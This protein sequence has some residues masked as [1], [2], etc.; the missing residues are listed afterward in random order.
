[1]RSSIS[2]GN[3]GDLPEV[4]ER[5]S[6]FADLGLTPV[7]RQGYRLWQ[8]LFCEEFPMTDA[9]PPVVAGSANPGLAAAA[10]EHLGVESSHDAGL[11]RRVA[12]LSRCEW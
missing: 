2:P 12:A 6:G 4:L 7:L 10:A 9:T 5:S 8:I 3:P 11:P 1:M